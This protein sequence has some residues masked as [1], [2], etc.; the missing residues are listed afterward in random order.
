MFEY[1][2]RIMDIIVSE[3][4][5]ILLKYGGFDKEEEFI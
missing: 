2:F 4:E 5:E 3:C 1:I